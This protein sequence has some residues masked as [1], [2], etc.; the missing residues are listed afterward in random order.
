MWHR[1][2][3][4]EFTPATRSRAERYVHEM[5]D[6]IRCKTLIVPAMLLGKT[7]V[8]YLLNRELKSL[9]LELKLEFHL[10]LQ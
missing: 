8:L 5:H 2:E 4:A 7:L 1:V 3:P 6:S 10:C 9:V